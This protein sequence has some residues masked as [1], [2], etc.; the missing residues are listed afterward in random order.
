[1]IKAI[2][3][4]LLFLYKFSRD[5]RHMGSV[6]PSSV[7]LARKMVEQVPWVEAASVAELGAG[8]G[9]ITRYLKARMRRQTKLLLFEKDA[10][11]RRALASEY[12]GATCHEDAANLLEAMQRQGIDRLDCILSGLPFYNFPQPTRDR[13]MAQIQAA[14][15]PGGLFVAFQYSQQMRK[16]LSR[17]FDV[18]AVHFVPLN[19][20]PAFVYV[21]RKR[22]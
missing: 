5:P 3:E 16:Q 8:T 21:C 6:T 11:L 9:A 12:T 20:P 19:I 15:K 22:R 10:E 17:I 1:M 18:E 4:K 7:F 14:L 2:Q 13:I